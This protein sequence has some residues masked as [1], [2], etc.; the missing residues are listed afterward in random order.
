MTETELNGSSLVAPSSAPPEDTAG[1][2][3]NL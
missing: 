2:L 1:N 3:K